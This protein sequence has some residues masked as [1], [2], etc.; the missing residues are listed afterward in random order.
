MKS[1]FEDIS[2]LIAFETRGKTFSYSTSLLLYYHF[3]Q[4]KSLRVVKIFFSFES[5]INN[6]VYKKCSI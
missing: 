2:I 4:F 1:N 3:Q 5:F 6:I